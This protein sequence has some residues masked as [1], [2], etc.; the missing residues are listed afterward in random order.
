MGTQKASSA[1]AWYN[2]S[3]PPHQTYWE[4]YSI[5]IAWLLERAWQDVMYMT[6]HPEIIKAKVQIGRQCFEDDHTDLGCGNQTLL[7]GRS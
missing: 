6:V 1:M 7:E 2:I 4:E 3:R 5:E